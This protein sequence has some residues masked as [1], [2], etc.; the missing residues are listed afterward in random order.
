L[1]R[2]NRFGRA[3]HRAAAWCRLRSPWLEA[4]AASAWTI[5]TVSRSPVFYLGL[6]GGVGRG[7]INTFRVAIADPP[8]LTVAGVS[9]LKLALGFYPLILWTARLPWQRRL[10]MVIPGFGSVLLAVMGLAACLQPSRWIALVLLSAIATVISR[11]RWGGIAV[12]L[13]LVVFCEPA[14]DHVFGRIRWSQAALAE[15]CEQNEGIRPT[16]ARRYYAPVYHGLTT[17]DANHLLLTGLRQADSRGIVDLGDADPGLETGSQWLVRRGDELT[18]LAPSQATGNIWRGCMVEDAMWFASYRYLIGTQWRG[19]GGET[20]RRI[21][22][23]TD[24]GDF[25]KGNTACDARRRAVYFADVM[26]GRLGQYAFASEQ[27]RDYPL[28]GIVIQLASR[29]DGRIL[30]VDSARL[31]VFDPD[32]WMVEQ[33]VPIGAAVIHFAHCERDDSVVVSDFLGRI[34]EFRPD[35]R[36]TYRFTW[37]VPIPGPRRIAYSPDCRYIAVASADDATVY[38]VSRQEQQIVRQ[39][40][41]GPV[42]RDVVFLG[43]REVAAVDACTVERLTF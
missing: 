15:R 41:I 37:G 2:A 30:A 34:R 43:P 27:L 14:L 25:D 1:V 38:V 19:G 8:T 9:A 7:V 12:V 26:A 42:L 35:A 33:Q 40:H 11:R 13:P 39:F 4:A 3:V 24:N 10:W 5:L 20:I 36:G 18:V 16:N 29:A 23:W 22:V 21:P 31:S 6:L 28:G 32:R 17:V